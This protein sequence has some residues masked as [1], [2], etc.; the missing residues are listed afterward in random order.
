MKRR[1]FILDSGKIG[2]G[3]GIVGTSACSSKRGE[4]EAQLA[5]KSKKE[6]EAI[7]K[8]GRLRKF[9]IS[10]AQWSLHKHYE[11]NKLDPMNF[12]LQAKSYDIHA[13]EYV[14]QLYGSKYLE[15]DNVK[16]AVEKLSADLL[17]K[18]KGEGVEN[19]L[20]M[21]DN[22]GDLCVADAALRKTS[23]ENH[24]KWVDAASYLEC[25][26]VRVNV[27]GEG[28]KEEQA[29]RA[30]ESLTMLSEYA[31]D[32]NINVIVENHGGYSSDPVWMTEVI[33]D[34]SMKNCGILPDFGNWC[35]RR[36]NNERWGALCLEETKEIYNAVEMML[37]WAKGV[38]AKSFAFD[39]EGNETT[40][41]Y[42]KMMQ[43]V[44]DSDYS[45]HIGVEYEGEV[46]AEI[47]IVR[48][49]KLLEKCM[50]G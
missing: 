41:D 3:L 28:S 46:D 31:A 48:T 21:I 24:Y 1:K 49:K 14:N 10:L 9:P 36:E 43:I 27:F 16:M 47:G 30:K 4:Y 23:V 13:L 29:D 6:M 37:P 18:S 42:R 45:G 15:A 40:I 25:H 50:A 20:I 5:D 34:V 22:E 7:K 26:S 33:E 19:V 32:M 8:M 35:I 17:T 44:S 39:I 11:K 2:L 12:A 38:S